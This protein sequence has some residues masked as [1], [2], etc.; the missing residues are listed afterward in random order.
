M[1]CSVFSG[2]LQKSGWKNKE[3]IGFR[4]SPYPAKLK[5]RRLS[6]GFELQQ[7]GWSQSVYIRSWQ[8]QYTNLFHCLDLFF[9]SFYKRSNTNK[10]KYLFEQNHLV[11]WLVYVIFCVPNLRCYFHFVEYCNCI[12]LSSILSLCSVI[13]FIKLIINLCLLLIG[14][15]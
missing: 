2:L 12:Y 13:F 10:L 1:L 15:L 4:Q 6:V 3:A 8:V 14:I 7:V 9:S 11:V 5:S